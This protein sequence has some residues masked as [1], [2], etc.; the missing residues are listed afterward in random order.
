MNGVHL[1]DQSICLLSKEW[2]YDCSWNLFA[3]QVH[4][5]EQI[6]ILT[7]YHLSP[8]RSWQSI[9]YHPAGLLLRR[10]Q[11][12]KHILLTIWS[13]RLR[14]HNK[15]GLS[16]RTHASSEDNTK[17]QTDKSG[18]QKLEDV[19]CL[20]CSSIWMAFQVMPPIQTGRCIKAQGN[21]KLF[22][23]ICNSNM[24]VVGSQS[25]ETQF[26]A[27]E[28]HLSCFGHLLA[29]SF[30]MVFWTSSLPLQ[31]QVAVWWLHGGFCCSNETFCPSCLHPR[32]CNLS[33]REIA[34]RSSLT[35]QQL[36]SIYC[37]KIASRKKEN[38]C[39]RCSAFFT[40]SYWALRQLS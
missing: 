6:Q 39:A 18:R 29:F 14:Y 25:L 5:D 35:V 8:S 17:R 28:E 1:I 19:I 36:Q 20:S 13:E 21:W 30:Q 2:A 24:Y 11:A 16:T 31:S 27:K 40:K 12:W 33:S 22:F 26:E 3:V 4:D 7:I 32:S 9:I 15:N 10:G 37:S 34:T 23:L 38:L